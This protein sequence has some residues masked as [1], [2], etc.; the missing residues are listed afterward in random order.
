MQ[1]TIDNFLDYISKQRGYSENTTAAYRRDL[2]QFIKFLNDELGITD[3]T[4]A[5]T[6]HV[7]RNFI[8]SYTESG[9]KTRTIARKVATLKSFSRFC[10]KTGVIK[11]NPAKALSTPKLD[12]P[13]PSF[14]TEKQAT[15]FASQTENSDIMAQRNRAIVELFYGTGMRLSEL[16]SLNTATIDKKRATIRVLG[17]G[18][19]ERI[20]PVTQVAI[21]MILKY[22]KDRNAS[23]NNTEPLFTNKKN[24]RLSKRQIQRIVEKELSTVSSQKKR[25]PHILRHTYATHLLDGGAD[26]RA[27]KELL[28][29]SSLSTTQIYTH[30]S[31]EHL[32]K[33][34]AQAHPRSG[35]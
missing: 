34:Y 24:D 26:I 5:M 33:A 30:V 4:T 6:K 35:E 14:L 12:K 29:H 1:K 22:L 25:S 16:Y 3:I 15:D 10:V 31:K 21:D 2:S 19:K 27:V 13:L 23:I 18:K 8:Y 9:Y 17:K 11:I 7:L 20:I 28:G 32:L